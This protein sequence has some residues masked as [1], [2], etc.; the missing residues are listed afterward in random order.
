[1]APAS[2]LD[3]IK[4]LLKQKTPYIVGCNNSCTTRPSG[5]G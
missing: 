1:M 3:E 2:V 5:S 4:M